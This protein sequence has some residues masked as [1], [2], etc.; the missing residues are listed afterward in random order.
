V[1]A[2][3]AGWQPAA[4]E[5][6]HQGA[7]ALTHATRTAGAPLN[8]GTLFCNLDACFVYRPAMVTFESARNSCQ[9]L[10]GDLVAYSSFEAQALVEKYFTKQVPLYS[11]WWVAHAAQAVPS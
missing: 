10:G 1:L 5:R 9:A 4:A 2:G 6:A 7:L 8:N 3:S 11:Y